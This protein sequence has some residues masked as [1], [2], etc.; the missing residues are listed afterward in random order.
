MSIYASNSRESTFIKE[1]LLKLKTHIEPHTI[2]VKDFNTPLSSMNRSWKQKL[3]R[4]TVKLIEVM[5]QM[6]LTDIYRIFHPKSKE[7]HDTFCRIDQII[8]HKTDLDRYKKIEII[9]CFL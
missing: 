4:G 5:D 7:P 3:N 9:P 2:I 1:P 8:S 6:D